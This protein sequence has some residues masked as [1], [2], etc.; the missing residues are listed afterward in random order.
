MVTDG[1]KAI[2]DPIGE[3]HVKVQMLLGVLALRSWARH[4]AAW[5]SHPAPPHN[6]HPRQL[7]LGL[8]T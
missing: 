8:I 6:S 4:R 1:E 5:P 3:L 2:L 7:Q